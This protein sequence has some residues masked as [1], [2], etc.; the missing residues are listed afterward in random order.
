[1]YRHV[2]DFDLLTPSRALITQADDPL[3]SFNSSSFPDMSVDTLVEATAK[4]AAIAKIN[5]NNNNNNEAP[6][7][8]EPAS[9]EGES[10]NQG[11]SGDNDDEMSSGIPP[12]T[13]DDEWTSLIDWNDDRKYA[14]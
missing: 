14:N 10:R 13:F 2:D 12:L 7:Q 5:D 9:I 6:R 11:L 8:E 4:P 3:F 1:M